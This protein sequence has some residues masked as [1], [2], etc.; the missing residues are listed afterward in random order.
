MKREYRRE[1]RKVLNHIAEGYS[2]VE[3][4]KLVTVETG[5][6]KKDIEKEYWRFVMNCRNQRKRRGKTSLILTAG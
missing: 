6:L 5:I 1:L 4:R 2:P 3:A